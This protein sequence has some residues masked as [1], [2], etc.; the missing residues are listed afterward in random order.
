MKKLNSFKIP[1]QRN[2]SHDL[3]G[4]ITTTT[5]K[6]NNKE[7]GDSSNNEK[8]DD[9]DFYLDYLILFVLLNCNFDLKIFLPFYTGLVQISSNFLF[10]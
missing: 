9:D 1:K 6:H 8:D 3:V 4:D 7:A 5:K 2:F 10:I